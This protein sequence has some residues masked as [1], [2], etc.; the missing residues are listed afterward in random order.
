MFANDF[1]DISPF[2][3]IFLGWKVQLTL[4][5]YLK[6]YREITANLNAKLARRGEKGRPWNL[7]AFKNAVF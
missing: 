4:N 1:S 2:F 5:Q 6:K 7:F 3:L